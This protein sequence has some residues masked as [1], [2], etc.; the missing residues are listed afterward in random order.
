MNTAFN[1]FA[2]FLGTGIGLTI[3]IRTGVRVGV[4]WAE[5]NMVV[6]AVELKMSEVSKEEEDG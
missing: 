2:F 4:H 5:Q 1:L 3:G 6:K